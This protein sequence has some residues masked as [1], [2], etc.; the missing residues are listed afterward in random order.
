MH[1]TVKFI[2]L[3]GFSLLISCQSSPPREQSFA[4][5]ETAG[6]I[7]DASGY[8]YD[9]NDRSCDGFPKLD[10]GTMPGTCLGLVM[11]RAKAV[12]AAVNVG[13]IMPRTIQQ[14]P[15]TN[16][17]L[18][19]DMGGW[20]QNNG[21]LFWM[22]RNGT[23][24]YELKLLKEKLNLPHGLKWHTDGFV[25][26]GETHQISRFKFANGTMSPWQLVSNHLPHFKDHM[27]PLTQFTFDPV[28]GDL[29]MNSGAP[30][31][32]CSVEGTQYKQCPDSEVKGM[33]AI[34]RI[35][36][37]KLKNIPTGGIQIFEHTASGLRNSMAMVV[38]ESGTLIQ[39]ENSRDFP[40]LE[41]PYEEINVI[42]LAKPGNHYGWPYCYD[43]HATSPEWI[44]PEAANTDMRKKF[45]TRLDCSVK[46]PSEIGEYQAP[47]ILIPP[48]AAP[49]D[50][51]YY[52]SPLFSDLFGGKLVVAWHGY[53]PTGHRIVAY[54]IDERGRPLLNS[55]KSG[56]YSFDVA[57]GC[58]T[59]KAYKPKGGMDRHANYTEI[60]GG[61]NAI[62]GVRAKGAPV[63]FTIAEDGSMY[64]VEDRENRTI[65]RLARTNEAPSRDACGSTGGPTSDARIEMLAWRNAVNSSPSLLAGYQA[66]ETKLINKYCA[67]CHG[68]FNSDDVRKDKFSRLD[69]LV[70]ND[71][72]TAGKP[73]LSKAYQAISHS[74]EIPAMPPTG[75]PQ[76]F[77]TPEGGQILKTVSDW[78]KALP[79]DVDSRLKQVASPGD[80][81]IR[82]APSGTATACGAISTEDS[83]WIDP[84]PSAQVAN[85]NWIWGKI[86]LLP[87]DS[88]LIPEK[89][90]Y[91]DD[92]VFWVAMKKQ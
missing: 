74:G 67:S 44:F 71:F 43:F 36:A 85:G 59:Q 82:S 13:F 38:H 3:T 69:F 46:S 23:A 53:Q 19:V 34:Y 75:I 45:T 30:T 47:W 27:H 65:L 35:P 50:M 90:A 28:S 61:W 29:F 48:H 22:K 12:D 52:R 56:T 11:P 91:P 77:G 87:K 33:G 24:P 25:Y 4:A 6:K 2:A 57:G 8:L 42:D 18:I 49:L 84:R 37:E 60:I 20:K 31:D 26:L 41:E 70:K 76:F 62:K 17:F 51:H 39:G 10:V 21:R 5:R 9:P 7:L 92:G 1:N 14:I 78:I 79:T 83:V 81:T 72:F 68:G 55:N 63:S 89:C 15:G 40:E 16:Q 88:R 54:D 64:I 58:P 32:H 80:R 73:E 66:V 86:Y